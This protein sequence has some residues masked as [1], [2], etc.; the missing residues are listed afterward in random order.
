MINS[1]FDMIYKV[2]FN[3]MGVKRGG[4]RSNKILR[5]PK[6]KRSRTGVSSCMM[7]PIKMLSYGLCD[8]YHSGYQSNRDECFPCY[9]V[10]HK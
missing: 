1:A 9:N 4:R 10:V 3:V 8:H 5:P 6:I 2:A 7:T